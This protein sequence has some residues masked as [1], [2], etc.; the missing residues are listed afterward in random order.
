MSRFE[1]NF[2]ITCT[3]FQ[4][5]LQTSFTMAVCVLQAG[6][7]LAP[8]EIPIILHTG[9]PRWPAHTYNGKG[10]L[11]QLIVYSLI[12]WEVP[13]EKRVNR[14]LKPRRRQKC[15]GLI[16]KTTTLQVH[17]A[18]LY[19]SSSSLHDYDV[20][21]PIF[22]FCGGREHKT[23]TFSFFSWTSIRSFTIQLPK[24]NCQHLENWAR[25]SLK[26]RNFTF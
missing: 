19:I 17:H 26:Q 12:N 22:T 16:C 5:I 3:I 25:R 23:T 6:P 8:T 15:I 24:K 9:F 10:K 20:K 7:H 11:S 4:T 14:E 2:L 13:W 18:F 1:Y 21:M